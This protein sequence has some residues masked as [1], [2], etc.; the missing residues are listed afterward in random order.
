MLKTAVDECGLD[1]IS[2]YSDDNT[3]VLNV[4]VKLCVC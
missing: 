2:A 3:I 4:D 1:N